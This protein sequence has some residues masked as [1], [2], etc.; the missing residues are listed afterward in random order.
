MFCNCFGSQ[1]DWSWTHDYTSEQIVVGTHAGGP[2]FGYIYENVH[3]GKGQY[4][5]TNGSTTFVI[6]DV[7]FVEFLGDSS[8]L[9]LAGTDSTEDNSDTFYL[10]S[11]V[12]EY[13]LNGGVW[14]GG[15]GADLY[16]GVNN[17]SDAG[18]FFHTGNDT[19]Y[20]HSGADTIDGG[21]G[22]R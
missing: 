13:I 21:D 17:V 16:S 4:T 1:T 8:T 18:P 9:N 3:K 2:D 20:G 22:R 5:F 7:E 11:A 6:Q 15:N 14:G 12:N 19:L 10:E